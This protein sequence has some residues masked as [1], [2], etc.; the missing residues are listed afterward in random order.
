[1]I[2][3]IYYRNDHRLTID[4]HAYHADPGQDIVCAAASILCYT[5]AASVNNMEAR[6][7]VRGAVVEVD[8]EYGSAVVACSHNEGNEG[9]VTTAFDTV[10]TG[11]KL[12]AE[13]YPKNITYK[14]VQG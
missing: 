2:T 10:C 3:A 7:E 12:L 14:V 5:L 13:N 6:G 1:M 8:D 11:L 9:A 4:G